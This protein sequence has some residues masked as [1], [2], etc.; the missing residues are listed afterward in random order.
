MKRT[1]RAPASV[2]KGGMGSMV[3]HY[4]EESIGL[5]VGPQ[6]VLIM[7]LVFIG[8]VILLHIWGYLSL[9]TY[10]YKYKYITVTVSCFVTI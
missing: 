4:S 10:T 9:R 5:K 2:N 3:R 1:T 8:F 7:S 6:A